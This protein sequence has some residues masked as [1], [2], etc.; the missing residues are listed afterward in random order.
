[1]PASGRTLRNL[2]VMPIMPV[3]PVTTLTLD[4]TFNVRSYGGKCLDFGPLPNPVVD[5]AT[6]VFAGTNPVFINDC[7][8]SASQHVRVV[9]LTGPG[10]LV[11]LYAGPGTR[12]LGKRVAPVVVFASSGAQ[13]S[14]STSDQIALEVQDYANGA[15]GQI[16]ALDGD[17]IIL[18]ADRNLVVEVQNNRGSKGTPLVLGHRDLD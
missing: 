8:G 4:N 14:S 7:N 3:V 1:M 15:T 16:F 9:E 18:A 13:T 17:S 2:P 10:H 5:R 12:V 11:N 6:A